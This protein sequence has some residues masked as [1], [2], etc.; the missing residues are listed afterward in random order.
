MRDRSP[1]RGL[2]PALNTRSPSVVEVE[3]QLGTPIKVSG[4]AARF[5]APSFST[6][7][8]PEIVK[9]PRCGKVKMLM[10]DLYDGTR[11]PEEHLGVYKAQMY[12]QD[13]D[14]TSY[15]RYFPATLKGVVQSWF[16]GLPQGSITC[17]QDLAN[18]F[19][20][21]FV[22]SRKERRT[23]IHLSKIK[24]GPQESLVE[25][26]RQFHQEAVLIPELEDG[27]A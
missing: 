11:D 15:C 25:F 3:R 23:S 6:P 27:V 12:V 22:A 10:L 17:F 20:G 9:A 14:D 16:N 8:C 4:M 18:K 21:Q 7:F 19:V 24:Q 5:A 26:V 2:R 13:V 1:R